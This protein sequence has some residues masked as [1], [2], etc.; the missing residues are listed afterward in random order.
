MRGA[1]VHGARSTPPLWKM[2][3]QTI[4]LNESNLRARMALA[5]PHVIA[6]GFLTSEIQV[7]TLKVMRDTTPHYLTGV[8]V[9]DIAFLTTD[10]VYAAIGQAITRFGGHDLHIDEI[11]LFG[12]NLDQMV[13]NGSELSHLSRF[14]SAETMVQFH[15]KEA[16]SP[17]FTLRECIEHYARCLLCTLEGEKR[18]QAV[19]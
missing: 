7:C 1:S 10:A 3:Q 5:T 8:L 12:Q 17:L 6:E 15:T 4:E 16:S 14:S 18:M 19:V 13:L 9:Q 11:H 2:Q